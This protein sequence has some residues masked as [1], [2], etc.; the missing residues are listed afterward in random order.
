MTTAEVKIWNETVGVVALP[1]GEAFGY[2]EFDPKFLASGLQLAP[3]QMPLGRGVFRFPSLAIQSFHGL[4]GMLADCLPDKF[5]N[6]LI[7]AWVARERR[8][9]LNAVERLCYTGTRGMGALEF[10]PPRGPRFPTSEAVDVQALVQL[11]S[12]VLAN[13]S[14]LKGSMAPDQREFALRDILRV[15]TS[16]GGARAKAV[17]AWNPMTDELRS[18]QVNAGDGFEHWLLKFDGVA[19]NT[20]HGLALPQGFGAIEFAYFLMAR[21]AKLEMSECR[22]L[23]EHD[24]RHFMTKRFDRGPAGEKLHMQSLGA[25]EHLDFNVPGAGSYEG[26]LWTISKLGLSMDTKEQMF[27]RMVFN[28]IARNQDDH[29]KNVAF[30]MNQRGEW[31]LAPAYDITY[32]FNPQ[33][34]WTAQ[35]Q[36]SING[37]R[38]GFT[39]EDFEACARSASMHRGRAAEIVEEVSE[40]V[41]RWPEHAWRASVA[42]DQAAAI[43]ATFRTHLLGRRSAAA[44]AAAP[45]IQRERSR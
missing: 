41:T 14:R 7:D 36:M 15:G 38:D 5:G 9:G 29:V 30:L 32:S 28:V 39:M 33:S 8:Q 21:A 25:L 13:R 31:S 17:L 43:E 19:A 24:R 44:A 42:E 6:A 37:K 26:A 34:V 22:L 3:L 4:P 12:E 11:A 27:R 40:A 45:V 1:D 10:F 2:F 16:A 18:G 23:E 20:D 35:H